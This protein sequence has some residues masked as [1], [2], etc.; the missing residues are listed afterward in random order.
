MLFKDFFDLL[1]KHCKKKPA[2]PDLC[3]IL[4]NSV[5]ENIEN[6]D[7]F[8][9]Y[10]KSV[11]SRILRG[12][13][14][15]PS[16]V[17]D[18]IYDDSVDEG[19]ADYFKDNIVPQLIPNHSDL[20]HE[21]VLILECNPHISKPHFSTFKA[22]A[23]EDT[24]GAFLSEVFRCAVI[25]GTRD[26]PSADK[27][28]EPTSN[29]TQTTDREPALTLCGVSEDNYT[30]NN[31]VIEDFSKKEELTKAWF[32]DKLRRQIDEVS[33]IH[34]KNTYQPV[35]F[36]KIELA[37]YPKAE[38]QE[39]TIDIIKA[40][41]NALGISLS[42]DFFDLGALKKDTLTPSPL[43]G[44]EASLKGSSEEKK[45]YA[46]IYRLEETINEFSRAIPF[47]EAFEGIRFI[48]FAV[49][50]SGTMFDEN[51]S[52]NIALPK[53]SLFMIKNIADI[54][55]DAYD[56]LINEIDKDKV[57]GIPRG[58]DY[59]DY[60]SSVKQ[61]RPHTV[62]MKPINDLFG[63]SVNSDDDVDKESELYDYFGYF[64]SEQAEND[65]VSVR[66]DEI[67]HHDAVALPSIILIKEDVSAIQF[68]IHSKHTAEKVSAQ[69]KVIEE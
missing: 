33:A 32:R 57:F 52:V 26:V 42:D 48:R 50:N 63:S 43:L 13:R 64:T 56:Y 25:E 24:L 20:I 30:I 65:I 31:F 10:D 15:I 3:M 12:E 38:I 40:V 36:G 23:K 14:G 59:L 4:F 46:L 19:I 17:R 29:I 7:E 60:N 2:D 53:G 49:K 44:V 16:V 28:L 62:R 21:L 39:R 47:I 41:S 35:S 5:I 27:D 6:D 1:K 58:N 8:Y 22:L 66:I 51:I 45:K 55:K 34:L 18:H 54:E 11:V 68:S 9:D 37:L 69:I 67:M 61:I